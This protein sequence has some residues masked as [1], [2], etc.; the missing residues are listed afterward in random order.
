[1]TPAAMDVLAVGYGELLVPRLADWVRSGYQRLA[2]P[3]GGRLVERDQTLILHSGSPGDRDLDFLPTPDWA[4]SARDRGRGY[5][6]LYYESVRGCPYRCSFCNYP[7]LFDDTKFRYK[8]ARK[9]AD[10][11]AAYVERLGVEYITAL[12]SLF[13][14]PRKRLMDFCHLLI[15]RNTRVKWV[16]YA[17]A[18]D[19]QD[20]DVVVS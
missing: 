17:R 16:C 10:E 3:P 20:L 15:A 9:M 6:M 11:W 18:D 2:P 12:D 19:L 5:R 1:M 4:L 7:F 14:M 13:T 8:S